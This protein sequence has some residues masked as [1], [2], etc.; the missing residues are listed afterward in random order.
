MFQPGE[1]GYHGASVMIEEGL[2]NAERPPSA[3]FALHVAS[4]LPTG[5]AFVRPGP[6][7]AS[8]DKLLITVRGRGGHA[9]APHRGLDPVP[10]AAEIVLALQSMVTR[11][12]DVFDPAVVTIAHIEAGTT[13]NVIPETVFMEGTVRAL[14][15]ATR[16]AVLDHARG[17]VEGVAGAHGLDADFAVDGGYPATINDPHMA[18]LAS[19]VAAEVLGAERSLPMKDPAMGAEDFSYVLERVPGAMIM[20]GAAPPGEE[21]PAANH[22]NRM[23][24]DEGAMVNGIALYAGLAMRSLSPEGGVLGG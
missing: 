20:L 18:A 4:F 5:V 11:R 16:A 13:N 2:L 24:L 8:S 15:D 19:E 23:I 12:V 9:S 21:S 10:V 7:L 3:A 6:M 1:E 17:V 22:S 14:S